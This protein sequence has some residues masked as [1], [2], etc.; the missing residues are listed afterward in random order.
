MEKISS[1]Y[2]IVSVSVLSLLICGLSACS[3]RPNDAILQSRL[4]HIYPDYAGVT[5]PVGIAP[6]N[7]NIVEADEE[8]AYVEVEGSKSGNLK[9][10]GCLAHF[11]VNEWH[12][13]VAQNRGGQ[14]LFKV[15]VKRSGEWYS[16]RPFSMYVSKY[17][18]GEW[19]MTYRLVAPS[20]EIFSKMGI[21]QRN[22]SN[23]DEE[24]ILENTQ[25]PGMCIN[26]HTSNRTNPDAFTFHVRGEHGATFVRYNGRDEWLKAKNEKLGGSMVYPYWHPSGRYCAFSTNDTH[27]MFHS[28]PHERIEVYDK[29]SDVLVYD[30]AHHRILT[31]SLISTKDWSENIP[32]FSPDG[33]S[34]YFVSARQQIYPEDYKKQRYNLCRISFDAATGKFG[35]KV[36][37]LIDAASMG[38]SIT[39]PR[40]SYD[41]R[42]IM[43]TLMD[44]GYF[45]VWHNE[46]DLWLLDL[47]TGENRPLR[48]VNSKRSES[49]HNWNI[50][51]HW[52]F[53]TSRRDD[54]LYT[55]IYFS[56]IDD[57]GK[58][59]KPFLLPQQNP[60]VYYRRLMYSYNT[61]DFTLKPVKLNARKAGEVIE[62]DERIET[63]F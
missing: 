13:F 2:T 51:S 6:M 27:Q 5:I 41:G 37:T 55:R 15:Y 11:D 34:L 39:W 56:S 30:V 26:C 48:D 53:F 28:T 43:Y 19:G 50:N 40:P 21:Y 62:S 36:D 47:K 1:I 7:F 60:L 17:T 42:Y 14:L 33:K 38:K 10:T 54:G 57:H 12:D 46:S 44:Y 58:V 4:P 61:P 52:F 18:L 3:S 35:N 49:L 24:A 29:K 22:L 20:Y 9:S 32:V 59:T 25:V 8:D 23:F 16:Y 45:S 63:R 31:D